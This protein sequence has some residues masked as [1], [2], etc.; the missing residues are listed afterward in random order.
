MGTGS[1]CAPLL[2]DRGGLP[3]PGPGKLGAAFCPRQAAAV[4][5][6]ADACPERAAVKWLHSQACEEVRAAVRPPAGRLGG[7]G[8]TTAWVSLGKGWPVKGA[9]EAQ[10][11]WQ[12][13]CEACLQAPLHGVPGPHAQGLCQAGREEL[14]PQTTVCPGPVTSCL[15][16]S[17][18]CA[19]PHPAGGRPSL[20]TAGTFPLPQV[21]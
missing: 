12:S 10:R 9:G 7:G 2:H 16:A 4:S 8:A 15:S 11:V 3:S 14:L 13:C 18:Q 5:R 21:L 17:A 19:H 20:I 6:W 1:V